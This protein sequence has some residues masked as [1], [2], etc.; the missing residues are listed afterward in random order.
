MFYTLTSSTSTPPTLCS[1]GFGSSC[2]VGTPQA[3]PSTPAPQPHPD[4]IVSLVEVDEDSFWSLFLSNL[5]LHLKHSLE[6]YRF[7][8]SEFGALT[9]VEIRELE[10]LL[11]Y[12]VE[13]SKDL[14]LYLNTEITESAYDELGELLLSLENLIEEVNNG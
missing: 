13:S 12:G 4:Y 6:D 8:L 7:I 1:R 10:G 14:N 11:K 9:S 5:V 3:C 2:Y